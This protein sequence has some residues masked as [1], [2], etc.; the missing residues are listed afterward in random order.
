MPPQ[1]HPFSFGEETVNSGEL[2]TATCAIFK[3][4]LPINITWTLNGHNVNDFEGV[5]A[6][7]TKRRTSQLTIES[8][9]A[10][11]SGEY[12]C[13]AKNSAG[14]AQYSSFLNVN[15]IMVY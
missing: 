12:T 13:F 10:H 14:T 1:I 3:G 15:G 5:D 6:G 11:H 8:V 2:V 7:N 9:Q 4:D